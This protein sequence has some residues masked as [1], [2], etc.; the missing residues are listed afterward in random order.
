MISVVIFLLPYADPMARV[1]GGEVTVAGCHGLFEDLGRHRLLDLA[2]AESGDEPDDDRALVLRVQR[3]TDLVVEDAAVVRRA[4]AVVAVDDPYGLEAAEAL[5]D[6]LGRERSEPLETD[7]ADL[8]AALLPQTADGDLHRERERGLADDD[9]LGIVGHVLVEERTVATPAEDPLEVRVRLADD[10]ERV[11]HRRVVLAPDLH[12]PVLVD[13]RRDRDRVV[14]VQQTIAEVE[15]RQERVHRGLCRD[16]HDVLRVCEERAVEPDRDRERHALVLTDAPSHEREVER[17]LGGLG[18]GQEPAEVAHRERVVVL[19][20]ERA[21]VVERAIAADRDDRQAEASGHG[22][23]LEGVEPTHTRR[24]DEDAG[25]DGAG[26]LHDLELAVLSVGDDVLDVHLAVGD[27]LR[28]GLH[29]A[30]VRADGVRRHH[31]DV[32]E[33]DGFGD[34]FAARRELLGLDL[35]R[36][37]GLDLD[38]HHSSPP[39][40][41][42]GFA[43]GSAPGVAGAFAAGFAFGGTLPFAP[44][45]GSAETPLMSSNHL[46]YVGRSSFQSCHLSLLSVNLSSSTMTMQSFTGQ[47]CAQMPQPMHASYTTS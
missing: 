29:H 40:D 35:T 12:E 13:L 31:V 5:H 9:H 15:L 36:L 28:G 24:A 33:A 2:A 10:A 7:E 32:G 25:A 11:P 42:V 4:E 44:A 39:A 30:V 26:V 43:A 19:R 16:L 18:P 41:V 6:L 3:G 22:D 1:A 46:L 27:E 17:L 37:F 45:L 20:A 14:R 38:N 8:E 23:R 21:G 34:G 47:T